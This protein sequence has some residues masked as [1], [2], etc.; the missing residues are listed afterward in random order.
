[1]LIMSE[2]LHKSLFL[3]RGLFINSDGSEEAEGLNTDLIING[4]NG[5]LKEGKRSQ[6]YCHYSMVVLKRKGIRTHRAAQSA[7]AATCC[8]L[9]EE[10]AAE[11]PQTSSELQTFLSYLRSD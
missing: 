10:T 2:I 7:E 5:A 9:K 3:F 6:H 4:S 8:R 11:D 1:M